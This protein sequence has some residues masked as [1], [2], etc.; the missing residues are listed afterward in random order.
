MEGR[1]VRNG[2]K[3]DEGL[4]GEAAMKKCARVIK[5][6]YDKNPSAYNFTFPTVE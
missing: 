1:L 6:E 3:W 5:A 2:S 4:G